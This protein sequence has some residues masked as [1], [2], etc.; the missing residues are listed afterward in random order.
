[1]RAKLTLLAGCAL[2]SL[3][4]ATPALAQNAK[5]GVATSD[6][7]LLEPTTETHSWDPVLSTYIRVPQQ[8]DLIFDV[9]L[10]CGLYTDTQVKTSGG[11]K[12]TSSAEASV[13]VRVKIE[14]WLGTD[15]A[16]RD[17]L[18]A[19]FHALPNEEAG[20]V[21]CSRKQTLSA[22]LQGIIENLACFPE[23]ADGVPTFDPDAPGCELVD[24]E[25]QLVLETLN[26]NAFNFVA[27]DLRSGD[28]KV[29]V[30]AEVS[31]DSSSQ[32]GSAAARGM[33]GLGSLV[34]DEVRFI[35]DEDTGSGG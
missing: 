35:K 10:Q 33:V 1:M 14:E 18:D 22:K 34:V 32:K 17:V 27:T 19:P 11:N 4:L 28:Y 8:E 30:E 5:T 31:S 16:G 12:D 25:I 29:T 7:I 20:V 13:A 21:F 24:E 2:T 9:A 23:N 15:G 3:I 26:A 6:A